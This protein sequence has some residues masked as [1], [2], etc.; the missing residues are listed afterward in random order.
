M[1]PY[2]FVVSHPELLLGVAVFD[3]C[4]HSRVTDI[5]VSVVC[6]KLYACRVLK[7]LCW[8]VCGLT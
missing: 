1:Y 4:S 3:S 8:L 5:N 2:N 7:L 6:V